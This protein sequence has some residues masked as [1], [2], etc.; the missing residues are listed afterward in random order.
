MLSTLL[1]K[2]LQEIFKSY[3]YDPK[4]NKARSKVSTVMYMVMYAFI[5]V[6]IL[7]GMFTGFAVFICSAFVDSGMEW[8]Y[9]SV[10]G[11]IAVFLG[12]FGSVFSTYSSLYLSKDNDLLL[13]MPIPVRYIMC[14]RLLGVYIMGLMYSAVVII[15]AIIVYWAVAPF[16]L[17]QVVCSLLFAAVISIIVMILSCVLGWVVA[18]ISLKLKNKSIITVFA[19]LIF[20]GIYYFVYFKAQ[21]FIE[22]MMNN[23]SVYGAKIKASVYPVYVF[24]KMAAGDILSTAVVTLAVLAIFALVWYVIS[25]SFIKIATASGAV[26]KTVYKEKHVRVKSPKAALLGKELGK[27]VSSPNYML[28]CGFSILLLPL[29][30]IVMIVMG[31]R[32]TGAVSELFG[33]SFGAVIPVIIC[34]V[35]FL[36]S[37]MNNMAAPSVSLEGKSLWLTQSLPVTPWSVLQSKLR[38]Q[39]LLTLIPQLFCLICIFIGVG[40][41]AVSAVLVIINTVMFSLFSAVSALG[42]G[43]KMPNLSW[44]NEIV[45]IKQSAPVAITML[46]GWGVGVVF[47]V[48]YFAVGHRI[49]DV[50]YLSV[51]AAVFALLFIAIYRWLRRRGSAIFAAL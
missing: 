38:L 7:G 23:L 40:C 28:N 3:Y 8:M 47:A 13:S 14:S 5:M 26:P 32:I 51:S 33:D 4:K 45:P 25:H 46:G 20:I 1:K 43:V 27:F 16:S 18:K 42:L 24:G 48:L 30:G 35:M 11:L 39:L 6:G 29:L 10:F 12:T 17:R 50:A 41:S 44:T 31:G 19:S 15:P 21:S 36:A 37:A 22:D 34:M 9:F 2:E 49:G